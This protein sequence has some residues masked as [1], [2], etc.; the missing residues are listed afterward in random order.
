MPILIAGGLVAILPK[1]GDR[2]II[3]HYVYL[4]ST[5]LRSF[6]NLSAHGQI[7]DDTFI[8]LSPK[9]DKVSLISL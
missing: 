5:H 1:H 8:P 6:L 4:N 7:V 3:I 2:T 9:F